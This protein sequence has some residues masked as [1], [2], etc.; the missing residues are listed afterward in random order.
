[1]LGKAIWQHRIQ[2]NPLV[3]PAGGAYSAPAT[4]YLEGMGW[5]TPPQEPH[6]HLSDLACPTP[7]QN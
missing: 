3:D 4:P 7:L 2:E 1:M 6:S 5:L